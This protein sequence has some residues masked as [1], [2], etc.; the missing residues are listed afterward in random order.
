[1]MFNVGLTAAKTPGTPAA[2]F[3]DLRFCFESTSKALL[4]GSLPQAIWHPDRINDPG[5]LKPMPPRRCRT[6][7]G[8]TSN[9]RRHAPQSVD[10]LAGQTRVNRHCGRLAQNGD[11]ADA[12]FSMRRIQPLVAKAQPGANCLVFRFATAAKFRDSIRP[13]FAGNY[14]TPGGNL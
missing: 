14:E 6:H 7:I 4:Q 5:W 9:G 12:S 1:M 10:E 2:S 11:W 3:V 8:K 13:R